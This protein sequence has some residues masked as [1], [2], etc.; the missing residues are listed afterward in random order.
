MNPENPNA[1]GE[2]WRKQAEAKLGLP[3]DVP[4]EPTELARVIHEMRV[5]QVELE[6]QNEELIDARAEL[7]EN[8][9]R[10]IELYDFAPVGYFSISAGGF[11]RQLNL[12]G[13]AML[14]EERARLLGKSFATFVVEQDRQN[15]DRFLSQVFA[16]QQTLPCEVGLQGD[17]QD[18]VIASLS[19]ALSG[20]GLVCRMAAMD[21][22]E[23]RRVEAAMRAKNEDLDRIFELSHDLLAIAGCDGR[24][25]RVNPAFERMLGYSPEV[26]TSRDFMEFVHPDDREATEG[27][28]AR[29]RAGEQVMNFTNRYRCVKGFYRWLEWRVIPYGD[30]LQCAVARDITERKMTEDALR[31]SEEKFR[32]IIERSPTAMYL[33]Q[34][35]EGGRL[36]LTDANPAADK[37]LGIEHAGLIGKPLE[38]A[39]PKLVGTGVPEIFTAVASGEEESRNFEMTYEGGGISGDFDV[40]VFQTHPGT[41]AVAF[42]DISER[43]MARMSLEKTYEELE[44][45]VQKRTA[46]LVERTRQLRALAV[47][48]GHAEER[49]QRRI[50]GLIHEDLQQNLVAALLN[51]GL[52][53]P[54]IG[55]HAAV[56]EISHIE[57]IMRECLATARS[58]TSE[59]N[60]PVLQQ[61]GLAAAFKWVRT[62]CG[63]HYAMDVRIDVEDGADPCPEVSVTLFRCVRELLFNIVK[64]AGVKTAGLRM[65]REGG[66]IVKIEVSDEGSGFDPDEVRAREGTVGGFGLFSVRERLES[67]GGGFEIDSSPGKGS[68]LT[69][70]VPMKLEVPASR[71][72]AP[73]SKS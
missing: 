5:H 49:E 48:L 39:F 1:P 31:V 64:H 50:A 35:A 8:S 53:K 73:V 56:E 34:L 71:D 23:Q 58:L 17:R 65:W 43:R 32:S 29:L 9:E 51:I 59:L 67:L 22:T 66:D 15:F 33:Y 60:P 20:D 12:K 2:K 13:A 37:E 47:D 68:R 41:I 26:M 24:F 61:C 7:E 10:L 38:Q 69:L 46:Q 4:L 36:I 27:V 3:A 16:G 6:L 44:R 40:T 18:A 28:L 42:E 55:E 52:L 19:G 63:E 21:V 30:H 62:W 70:W 72:G 25:R 14:G 11:I 57:G 45:R 54:K